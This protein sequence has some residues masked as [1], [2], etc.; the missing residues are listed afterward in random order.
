MHAIGNRGAS[1]ED[2]V[3]KT[4]YR[5][6]AGVGDFGVFKDQSFALGWMLSAN[7]LFYDLLF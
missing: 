1:Q 6:W 2:G 4:Y 7:G 5:I 3:G